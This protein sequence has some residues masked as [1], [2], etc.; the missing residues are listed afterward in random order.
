MLKKPTNTKGFLF[1]FKGTVEHCP[2]RGLNTIEV[3]S[4]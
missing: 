2:S 1:F 3:D 4:P